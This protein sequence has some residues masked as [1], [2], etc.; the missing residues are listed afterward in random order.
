MLARPVRRNLSAD[1]SAIGAG[2]LAGLAL[3]VWASTEEL[4]ALPRR[5]DVFEPRMGSAERDRRYD[6]WQIAVARARLSRA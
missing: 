4:E 1:L 3:G 5:Q 6:G 2:W